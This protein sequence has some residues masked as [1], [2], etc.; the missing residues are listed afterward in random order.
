MED[1]TFIQKVKEGLTDIVNEIA[2]ITPAEQVNVEQQE[3]VQVNVEQQKPTEVEM[4]QSVITD[5]Q[6]RI[7]LLEAKLTSAEED[8]RKGTDS[9]TKMNSVIEKMNSLIQ[10]IAETPTGVP[11]ENQKTNVD[12]SKLPFHERIAYEALQNK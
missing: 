12:V 11:V 3:Q 6:N 9:Q 10:K 2:G 1:K 5:L 8:L 7:T 4:L